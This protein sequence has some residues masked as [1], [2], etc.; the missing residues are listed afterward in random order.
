MVGRI[1]AKDVN[2]LIP[3]AS[4]CGVTWQMGIKITNR[5]KF[6]KHL[7]LKWRDIL[8]YV[9]GLSVITN[10]LIN[11]RRWQKERTSELAK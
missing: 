11:G 9:I 10:A 8:N 2:A 7:T 5:I 3:R 4:E 1:V 6:A